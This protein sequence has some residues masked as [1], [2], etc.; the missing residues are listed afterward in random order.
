VSDPFVVIMNNKISLNQ[1]IMDNLE[2]LTTLVTQDTGTIKNRQ[3]RETDKLVK[4]ATGA[5][6]NG[7]SRETDNIGHTRHRGNQEWTI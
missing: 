6:K 5:I 3:S 1:S 2:R 4:Q 7:Q